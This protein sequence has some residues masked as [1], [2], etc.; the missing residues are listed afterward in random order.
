MKIK[1]LT[2]CLPETL[3]Q[4]L[5]PDPFDRSPYSLNQAVPKHYFLNQK[6]VYSVKK[7]LP[8]ISSRVAKLQHYLNFGKP[9][10]R[11]KSAYLKTL[12]NTKISHVLI[13]VTL[14]SIH[15]ESAQS[16]LQNGIDILTKNEDFG[17]VCLATKVVQIMQHR[18]SEIQILLKFCYARTLINPKFYEKKFL[19]SFKID[20]NLN[21]QNLLRLF[22][23][24]TSVKIQFLKTFILPYFDYCSTLLCYFSKEAIIELAKI[25]KA[26]YSLNGVGC[27]AFGLELKILAR[28]YSIYCQPIFNY[29]IEK[30]YIYVTC[31]SPMRC[32]LD[33]SL[34]I[35]P[36]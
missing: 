11:Y 31:S 6:S 36:I 32:S 28:L 27:R 17:D 3:N 26:L 4:G 13:D 2:F 8:F 22:Y 20:K 19:L 15:S 12:K 5:S 30:L 24:S 21:F 25:Q 33:I 16:H 18:I 14:L 23:L 9:T 7:I 35:R 1:T 34:P 10:L 29:G